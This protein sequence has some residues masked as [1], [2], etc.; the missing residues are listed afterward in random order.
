LQGRKVE[1]G[2]EPQRLLWRKPHDG[3]VWIIRFACAVGEIERGASFGHYA[4]RRGDGRIC[5]D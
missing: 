2:V 5:G 3:R 1:A 4:S